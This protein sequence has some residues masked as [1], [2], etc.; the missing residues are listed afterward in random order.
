MKIKLKYIAL[1]LF[2]VDVLLLIINIKYKDQIP[3]VIRDLDYVK[4][5]LFLGIIVFVCFLIIAKF[6]KDVTILAA[7]AII[8]FCLSMFFNLRLA[9]DN[10][11][12][13]QCN[14]SISEYSKYFEFDSCEKINKRFEEDLMN[15]E[16][17]YFQDKYNSDSEFEEVLRDKHGIELIGTSCSQ[18]TS[19]ECYND[20]VKEL[21]KENISE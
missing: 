18:F 7:I 15:G 2:L 13:I 19:M 5:F 6:K 11:D 14:N 9:K 1:A 21:F 17:K 16:L 8:F 20:L 12:R 3:S 10:Y 4:F